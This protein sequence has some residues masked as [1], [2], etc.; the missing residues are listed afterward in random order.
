[1]SRGNATIELRKLCGNHR[2]VPTSYKLEGVVKEGEIPKH[3]RRSGVTEIWKGLH[4]GDVVALKV[5]RVSRDD[6]QMQRIKSVSTLRGPLRARSFVVLM[7]GVAILQGG[8]ADDAAQ[9]RKYPS[10]LRG[11]HDGRRPLPGVSL[12]RQRKYHGLSE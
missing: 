6:P 8:G 10:F 9:A 3:Q 4:N 5:L 2:T 11:L 1:M 12:V 7:D